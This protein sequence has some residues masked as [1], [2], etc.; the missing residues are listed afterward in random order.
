DKRIE[1]LPERY[2]HFLAEVALLMSKE[3]LEAFLTIEQD[4]QRDAYIERFWRIRDTYQD[5]PVNE[6]K[7]RWETLI[8]TAMELFGSIEE[9]RS[10]ML[11]L[12]GPPDGRLEF[13]CTNVTYPLEVW[14]YDGSDRVGYEFYLIFYQK[15]GGK[16]FWLWR[17]RDGM[18]E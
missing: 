14:F 13:R 6:F 12:N 18:Q 9:D 11:L 3:E 4:Y 10:R 2:Q 1:A 5:T 17:P 8:S 15:M 16:R 7:E